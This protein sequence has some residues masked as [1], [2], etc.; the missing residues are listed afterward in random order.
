MGSIDL[1]EYAVLTHSS[2][3]IGTRVIFESGFAMDGGNMTVNGLLDGADIDILANT[4][5]SLSEEQTIEGAWTFA[6]NLIIT[7]EYG[8]VE[9]FLFSSILFF[10]RGLPRE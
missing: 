8:V 10:F 4:L 2:Q 1:S 3:T 7:G 6:Q 9:R 5:V